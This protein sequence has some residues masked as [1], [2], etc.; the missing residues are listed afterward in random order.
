MVPNYVAPPAAE[1]VQRVQDHEHLRLLTIGHYV[2]AGIT[3][4]LSLIPLFHVG[5]GLLMALSP[6]LGAP[7]SGSGPPPQVFGLLFVVIGGVII[8]A[9]E[10]LA[11][12]NYVA[13][14]FIKQ[15][16]SRMFIFVISALNCLNVP[17][18]ALLGIFTFI[19]L[20]RPSVR[21]QFEGGAVEEFPVERW[22]DPAA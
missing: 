12:L 10:T 6:T 9:G 16:R 21:T 5:F 13:G 3:A 15:R 20:S 19:V 7:P 14:R 4:V 11:A 17:L 1:D 18:G 8:V 22:P 2:Y